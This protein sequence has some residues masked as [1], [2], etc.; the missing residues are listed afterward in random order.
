MRRA[1]LLLCLLAVAGLVVPAA[2]ADLPPI[3]HVFLVVLE[4]KD[5]DESFSQ[6]GGSE[7]LART[8]PRQGELLRQYYGIGHESLDNY[9][10]MVSG[11]APNPQTRPTA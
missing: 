2:R 7:W 8:L 10:A 5:H 3:K 1:V 11:Q 6:T 4:N 9:L